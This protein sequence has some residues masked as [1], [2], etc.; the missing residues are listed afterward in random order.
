MVEL[1]RPNIYLL[2]L[3]LHYTLLLRDMFE[4]L[5]VLLRELSPCLLSR[6]LLGR[7]GFLRLPV[8]PNLL[9]QKLL[10]HLK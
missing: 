2:Q 6:S 8:G 10:L 7:Q 5:S 3:F 4:L 9:F 1:D